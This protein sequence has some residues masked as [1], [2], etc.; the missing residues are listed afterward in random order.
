MRAL[1]TQLMIVSIVG[2]ILVAIV[3]MVIGLYI[4][5]GYWGVLLA[6]VIAAVVDV[7]YLRFIRPWHLRWGATEREVERAMP[8]DHLIVGAPNVTRAISIAAD[9]EDVWP[10]L[11]QVGYGK[12]GWYSYDWIDNDFHESAAEIIPEHQH[13]DAGDRI[14]MMPTMGFVVDEVVAHHAIVSVLEDDST[15]WCLA[16]YPDESGSRLVSRWRP[17]D[18]RSVAERASRVVIEPGTFIMEQKM[19]RTIRDRVEHEERS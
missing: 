7:S 11:V 18:A 10:W 9:P 8:G 6:L 14:L 4:W 3:A 1:R 2:S 5:L 13:L 12:A 16:V 17:K 19:L 15:S